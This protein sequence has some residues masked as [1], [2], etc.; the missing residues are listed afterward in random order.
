MPG[1]PSADQFQVYQPRLEMVLVAVWREHI[2]AVNER[3]HITNRP[4]VPILAMR[5]HPDDLAANVVAEELLCVV[6]ERLP[7]FRSVD[8]VE[9]D[10]YL[11]LVIR[12]DVDCVAVHDADYFARDLVGLF[13][14]LWRLFWRCC[15]FGWLDGRLWWFCD[16]WRRL[17]HW[18]RRFNASSQDD[19]LR[20][21]RGMQRGLD[22]TMIRNPKREFFRIDP[23]Q[24]IAILRLMNVD[25]VT[26]QVK[27][28]S[29]GIDE[30][31][32]KA[33]EQLRKRRPNLNFEEMGIPIGAILSSANGGDTA[34]VVDPKKVQFRNH[35][36]ISLS[37]ATREMLGTEYSVAPAPHWTYDGKPLK[38]I[39]EATYPDY[40]TG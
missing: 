38:D 25:D 5:H 17:W 40:V 33:A 14:G 8:A 21:K 27:A 34:T 6:P 32:K 13:C 1:K 39:Y 16:R 30:Q 31:D 28:D 2:R 3:K 36:S 12:Q 37:A 19:A 4:P 29:E 7:R 18:W 10:P 22:F 26:D 15:W 20:C 24:A 9:S 35:D 23:G 11:C